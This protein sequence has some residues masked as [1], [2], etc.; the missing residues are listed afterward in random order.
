MSF[1]TRLPKLLR[2][3]PELSTI[4]LFDNVIQDSDVPSNHRTQHRMQRRFRGAF[5]SSANDHSCRS[6]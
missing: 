3:K 1:V 6:A 5:P 4:N 2:L